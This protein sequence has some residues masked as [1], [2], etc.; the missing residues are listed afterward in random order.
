MALGSHDIYA[1]GSTRSILQLMQQKSR[2]IG[3]IMPGAE[4]VDQLSNTAA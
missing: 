3:A 1:V 4:L 2:D